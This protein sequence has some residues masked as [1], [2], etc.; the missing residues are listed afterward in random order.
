MAIPDLV[1]ECFFT[2]Q[3]T[4]LSKTLKK[5]KKRDTIKKQEHWEDLLESEARN[6]KIEVRSN[7]TAV[8]ARKDIYLDKSI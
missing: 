6:L 2:K 4:L 8:M 1:V 7:N 3:R 5:P